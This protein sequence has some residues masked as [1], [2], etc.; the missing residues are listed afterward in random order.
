[1]CEER[2]LSLLFIKERKKKKINIKKSTYMV[3][4]RLKVYKED[5]LAEKTEILFCIDVTRK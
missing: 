3:N 1:M 2:Y 4:K 5:Y